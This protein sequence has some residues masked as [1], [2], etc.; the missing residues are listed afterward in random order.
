[1]KFLLS[2][3]LALRVVSAQAAPENQLRNGSFEG[4]LLY[5]HKIQPQEQTLVRDAEVGEYALRIAKGNVMSAPF[6]ADRG[7][8]MTVS[9]FVKG[10]KPGRV[11]VQMPPSAR[12]PGQKSKR[13]WTREAS[14]QSTNA[15]ADSV[16]EMT[17]AG[18]EK[19]I[20]FHI[21][22]E[23]HGQSFWDY[24]GPGQMLWDW[25]N[26]PTPLVAMWNVLNHHIGISDEVGLVRPP[27]ANSTIFQD[28]R[29]GR[30][31][32]IAYADRDSK[33]DVTVD[34]AARRS[35]RRM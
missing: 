35:P 26:Y 25:Y 24:S 22:Y 12:E 4:G 5:W 30:G 31:V 32:M 10:E 33:E 3:A 20:L 19:T 16:A 18:Q 21:A 9:F 14:A 6:V 15:Q 34:L 2:I 11:G 8:P 13:L 17:I 1:M 23:D 28:Q 27:G 7:E 29:N